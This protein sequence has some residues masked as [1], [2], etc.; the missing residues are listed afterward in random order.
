MTDC[1]DT[2]INGKYPVKLLP[3]RKE[4]HDARPGWEAERL[5]SCH[6]LMKPG[7][8]VYDL[9]SEEHDF[10]ALYRSWVGP[11]GK[12]VSVEPSPP[13]WPAARATFEGNGFEPPAAWFCGFISDVT[14]LNPP[15]DSWAKERGD[16]GTGW[17]WCSHG[18]IIPDFGFRHLA[19]QA[20][21]T[22]QIT[23]D[24]L[25]E[26][27]GLVPN[28]VVMDIEGAEFRA[29][30]GAEKTLRE[31]RPLMWVSI[32]PTTLWE[33]YQ[34]TTLEMHRYMIGLDYWPVFLG[35]SSE[36]LWGYFPKE[37]ARYGGAV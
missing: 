36:E 16:D 22:P 7:D 4:F 13:Y 15:K 10:T 33:W 29:L 12:V 20:D 37:R 9:G 19:E 32:H 24:D 31:Y 30:Q 25:V 14:D 26:A 27:T 3:H 17:P 2:L 18:K 21:S 1:V 8:T 28:G 35:A 34:A 11:E 23:L 6:E 5:V